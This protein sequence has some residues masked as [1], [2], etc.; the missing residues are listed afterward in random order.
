MGKGRRPCPSIH[1][2]IIQRVAVLSTDALFKSM[3]VPTTDTSTAMSSDETADEMADEMV[4]EMVD[5]MADEKADEVVDETVDT[6]LHEATVLSTVA[7]C[8]SLTSPSTVALILPC[9][10]PNVSGIRV[11]PWI[12]HGLWMHDAPFGAWWGRGWALVSV[13]VGGHAALCPPYGGKRHTN[14]PAGTRH[15][16]PRGA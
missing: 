16:Q 14:R 9:R 8:T 10:D 15:Q 4:D 7:L 2:P 6:P 5:E 3:T 11:H 13:C 12:P 1:L